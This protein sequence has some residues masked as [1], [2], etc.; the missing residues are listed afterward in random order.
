MKNPS[1]KTFSI[2]PV[3]TQVFLTKVVHL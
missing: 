3:H 1:V 2:F